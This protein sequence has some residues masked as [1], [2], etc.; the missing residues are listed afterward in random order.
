MH[1]LQR[2]NN[3][4]LG[5]L[6]YFKR[7]KFLQITGF[8]LQQNEETNKTINILKS[9]YFS[10]LEDKKVKPITRF[11]FSMSAAVMLGK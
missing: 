7:W 1:H 4:N 2:S 10:N 6:L 11:C 5:F 8:F 3:S 9:I